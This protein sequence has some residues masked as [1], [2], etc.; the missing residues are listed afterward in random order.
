MKTKWTLED[1]ENEETGTI[2]TTLVRTTD[3]ER[4]EMGSVGEFVRLFKACQAR[5]AEHGWDIEKLI[6]AVNE[7]P[8]D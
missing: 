3:G 4:D 5:W 7:C 1:V 2:E 8:F 6:T